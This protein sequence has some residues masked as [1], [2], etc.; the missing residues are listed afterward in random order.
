MALRML[1]LCRRVCI[2]HGVCL[3]VCFQLYRLLC[4][5]VY[6]GMRV[7]VMWGVVRVRIGEL[8]GCLD[9]G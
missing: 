7:C 8:D 1:G 4:R 9:L 2:C 5:P 3:V 6:I